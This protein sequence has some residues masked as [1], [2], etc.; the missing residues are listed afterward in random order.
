M[1]RSDELIMIQ[2]D[3][4]IPVDTLSSV[5]ELATQGCRQIAEFLQHKI[6]LHGQRCREGKS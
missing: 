4:Q 6:R 1:E 2:S 5:V 3:A